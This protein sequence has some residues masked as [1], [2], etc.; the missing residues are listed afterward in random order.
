MFDAEP[1]AA[2]LEKEFCDS[3]LTPT[4]VT[5]LSQLGASGRSR[6]HAWTT[7]AAVY[8][9]S[10]TMSLPLLYDD[11]SDARSTTAAA[12]SSWRA[13]RPK[14]NDSGGSAVHSWRMRSG[15]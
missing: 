8:A 7:C 5:E 15:A 11:S 6:Q 3:R 12:L 14:R 1:G 2:A 4:R 10:A 13:Q 9:P